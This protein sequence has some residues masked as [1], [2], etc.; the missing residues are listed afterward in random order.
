ALALL[1]LTLF[2]CGAEVALRW[3]HAR[4]LDRAARRDPS[5]ELCTEPDLDL[6]YR[7][8]AGRCGN[9]SHGYR[10]SEHALDQTPGV[11][12]FA[13]VGDSVAAGDGVTLD[14]RF[15]RLV[16]Q[17]LIRT[18][19]RA[20]A[21]NLARPGYSTAQELLVLEREAYA[22]HPDL[23]LWSYVLNDPADPVFHNANGQLGRFFVRPRCFV[24]HELARLSFLLRERIAARDCPQEFHA[25]LHCVYADRVAADLARIGEL[26]REHA[27]PTLFVIPPVFERDRGFAD[28]KL[29]PVH[30]EL[31]REARA[32]GL[33]VVD[34]LM[35][36]APYQPDE[37]RRTDQAWFDP[38]HPNARGHAVAAEAIARA[39]LEMNVSGK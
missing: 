24:C 13:V 12:R 29:A 8:K 27:T 15:D 20:E 1:S 17:E 25:L 31:A 35:A 38:W 3:Q 5:R 14:Q 36:Y 21:V 2:T 6:L 16:E 9:N 19:V 4:R 33:T 23:V 39:L 26:S 18:G 10:D 37:L 28:S 11:F 32:A 34:L 7:Y 22:Y 30:A